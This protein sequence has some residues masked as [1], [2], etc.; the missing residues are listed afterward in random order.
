MP[1]YTMKRITVAMEPGEN[2]FVSGC[3]LEVIVNRAVIRDTIREIATEAAESL[4]DEDLKHYMAS[5]LT[6][7]VTLYRRQ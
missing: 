3:P 4:T 7:Q 1:D 6:A 2:M 5:G